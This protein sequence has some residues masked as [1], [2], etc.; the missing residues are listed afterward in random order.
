MKTKIVLAFMIVTI[1][2]SIS[3]AYASI[4]VD[5][6]VHDD[7]GVTPGAY[8][9]S[10]WKPN[11]GIVYT[12]EDQKDNYLNPGY[13]G[14]KFDAEAMYA[15]KEGSNYYVAIVTGFAAKGYPGY[16]AGDIALDSNNDGIYE[17][18]VK[19]RGDN[20]GKVYKD[21][22]AA[23]WN[24]GYWGAVSD[25]TSIKDGSGTYVGTV[26]FAYEHTYYD[27]TGEDLLN[28]HWVIELG[29]PENYFDFN[30]W[31]NGGKIHWTMSCGNDPIDLHVPAATPEPATLSLLGLGLAGLL[32]FRKRK[33]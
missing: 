22:T 27:I 30:S 21:L 26:D 20:A 17:F 7:W 32:R 28:D 4:T 18:G 12:V 19:T 1:L 24:H 5:G 14:Q 2:I 15:T 8:G 10:D 33:I 6:Y 13:G 3:N 29:I 11:D 23:S 25:P 31:A 9:A 16:T